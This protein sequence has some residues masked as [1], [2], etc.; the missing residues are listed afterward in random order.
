MAAVLSTILPGAGQLYIGRR[1]RGAA[2]LLVTAVII[3]AMLALWAAGPVFVL[4]ILVR[5]WVLAFLLAIDVVV[6]G[7]HLFVIEDA[8]R[9]AGGHLRSGRLMLALL[10]ALTAAPH[11]VAGYYDLLTMDLLNDLFSGE[12]AGHEVVTPG[13]EYKLTIPVTPN[14]DVTVAP[15]E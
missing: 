4:K 6:L 12:R 13:E 8:Y 3:A 15:G 9:L 14:R 1:G 2:M 11:L 7:L 10:F 5:P